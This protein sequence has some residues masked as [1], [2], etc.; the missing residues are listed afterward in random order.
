MQQKKTEDSPYSEVV[1]NLQ[2]AWDSVSMTTFMDCPRKYQYQILEGWVGRNKRV[3]LE[4]GIHFHSALEFYHKERARG[5]GPEQ[6]AVNTLREVLRISKDFSPDDTG[7]RTKYTLLRSVLWYVDRFKDD[8]LH[9][10]ILP[11]ETPALELSFR[12]A[13]PLEGPDGPY[14]YCGH[15]DRAVEYE[16][17]YIVTDYKTTKSSLSKY[18]FK[19]FDVSWQIT[20][21]IFAAG[22]ILPKQPNRAVIDGVQLAIDF[23]RFDRKFTDRSDDQMKEWL[24]DFLIWIRLA[25]QFAEENYWPM[26]RSS[27]SKYGGCP[28]IETCSKEKG[29]LRKLILST[30]F[31]KDPW[32][33]LRSR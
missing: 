19:Q 28:F 18:F 2:T 13:L 5:V 26:N 27:C 17:D 20:G 8:P 30:D 16:G 1:P 9:T 14:L 24:D 4:F 23:N 31:V 15:I 11:D 22:T 7:H 3:E 6:S 25:E 21:Y 12:I 32:N 33:P 29:S 10:I